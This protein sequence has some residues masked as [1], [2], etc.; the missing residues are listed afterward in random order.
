MG[1]MFSADSL[2]VPAPG[3]GNRHLFCPLIEHDSLET[4]SQSLE[5]TQGFADKSES[6]NTEIPFP[7]SPESSNTLFSLKIKEP[8]SGL[9]YSS[10]E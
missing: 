6:E 10:R 5:K 8:P 4:Q 9:F 1:L 3:Q 2:Q 7:K